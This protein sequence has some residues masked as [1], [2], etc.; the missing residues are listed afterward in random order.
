[1]TLHQFGSADRVHEISFG[2][3]ARLGREKLD[4][5][6]LFG[7]ADDLE[8]VPFLGASDDHSMGAGSGAKVDQRCSHHHVVLR[9]GRQGSR[10][11]GP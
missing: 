3:V 9:G 6:P 11:G 4:F 2:H 7:L 10:Q 8:D 5:V 1:M